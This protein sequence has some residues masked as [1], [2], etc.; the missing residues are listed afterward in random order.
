MLQKIVMIIIMSS[1]IFGMI[2]CGENAMEKKFRTFVQDHVEK[3]EPLMKEWNLS[4]WNASLTGKKEDF[5]KTAEYELKIR[6]IYSDTSAFAYLKDLKESDQIKNLLLKRHLDLLYNA[7]LSNQIEPDMLKQIVSKSSAIENKF[8]VFRGK[9]GDQ[10]VTD[11]E[12]K[13]ILKKE[14]D[15]S[16]RRDAWFASKQVGKEVANDLIEL[17]KLRNQAAQELGFENYYLMSLTVSEQNLEELTKIFNELAELTDEPFAKMKTE[18]D[19]ILADRYGIGVEGMMPW[20]YHDPFFQEGPMVYEVNLDKYYEDQDVKELAQKFYTGINLAVDDILARSDLYEKQ[21]KNPH[22]YCTSIDRKEDVRILANIKNN[23]SWME[24]MLHELG[25]AV[26]DKYIDKSLPFLL[27]EPAHIFTTEAI[28]M[29]FGR[30][31]RNADWLQDMLDLG[32]EEGDKIASVVQKSLRL[33]QL[34][35]ARWCQVMFRFEQELYKNPDQNLNTLWWELVEKYQLVKR[36]TGRT[37]PDW[38]AKIHFT[39]APVYYHNYMLGELLA[40]QLHAY[41]VK[42]VLKLESDDGV[43][44]VNENIVGNYLKKRV[45]S[46]GTKHRWNEM[47]TQATGENLTAKYFVDQFVR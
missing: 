20:H 39:M 41:I 21:G 9:I 17:I 38:A 1:I 14:T 11:N 18:L 35:F 29:F 12:I 25:H 7:Y 37:E 31:S 23:E 19:S 2:G 43:S 42:N 13:E 5:D 8:N 32:D 15:S 45:F 28:A 44:Y 24:T 46:D 27:R 16:K 22:A 4:Y 40:S 26:Y 10:E 6:T 47:I 34:V 33:R 3:M 30:L 36:P